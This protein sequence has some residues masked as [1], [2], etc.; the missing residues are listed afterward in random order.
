[1]HI[2]SHKPRRHH[3]HLRHHCC[4]TIVIPIKHRHM[5]QYRDCHHQPHCHHSLSH[6]SHRHDLSRHFNNNIFK[7]SMVILRNTHEIPLLLVLEIV[8]ILEGAKGIVLARTS[9]ARGF[10]NIHF[11][12]RVSPNSEGVGL[13]SSSSSIATRVALG[14]ETGLV[15]W[16]SPDKFLTMVAFSSHRKTYSTSGCASSAVSHIG[17]CVA[18]PLIGKQST[19]NRSE[20]ITVSLKILT[21]DRN[22]V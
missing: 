21:E 22:M 6:A 20:R 11:F 16:I 3:R 9:P 8:V 19:G 5:H 4:H 18:L 15:D 13:L 14:Q 7:I 1:M 2:R 17:L 12:W 10:G